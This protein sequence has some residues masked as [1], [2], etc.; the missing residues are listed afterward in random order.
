MLRKDLHELFTSTS[1]IIVIF[2]TTMSFEKSLWKS[3]A[4]VRWQQKLM[5]CLGTNPSDHAFCYSFPLLPLEWDSLHFQRMW[6]PLR[7]M[8]H[9][10]PEVPKAA[11]SKLLSN[12]I[13]LLSYKS[14]KDLPFINCTC[15]YVM[16]YSL[17]YFKSLW[18]LF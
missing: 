13:V 4:P 3:A 1:L 9:I 7:A 2:C 12:W 16:F 6:K 14:P 15:C 11:I 18:L 5:L 10:F 8:F 17:F